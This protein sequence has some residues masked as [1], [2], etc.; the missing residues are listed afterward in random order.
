LTFNDSPISLRFKAKIMSNICA[1]HAVGAGG[2]EMQQQQLIAMRT[3]N[4]A[5]MLHR[6]H[7]LPGAISASRSEANLSR[8]ECAVCDLT[9]NKTAKSRKPIEECATQ[10]NP[11]RRKS[12]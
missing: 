5:A 6:L 8:V 10:I 4:A 2:N 11:T 3:G 1:V 7:T 12:Q 9:V